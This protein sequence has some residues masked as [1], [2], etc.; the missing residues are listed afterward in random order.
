MG[1]L[2]RSKTKAK[3]K[4]KRKQLN[5]TK[6]NR[7][8]QKKIRNYQ[9]L[10]FIIFRTPVCCCDEKMVRLFITLE[11][12]DHTTMVMTFQIVILRHGRGVEQYMLIG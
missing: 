4:Q 5:K 1:C 2:K 9:G 8:E 3:T 11:K 12:A 7:T 10:C 6:Q